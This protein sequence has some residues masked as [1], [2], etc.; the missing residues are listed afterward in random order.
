V[1]GRPSAENSPWLRATFYAVIDCQVSRA[2]YSIFRGS[3]ESPGAGKDVTA[4]GNLNGPLGLAI[5]PNG[6]ILTANGNDGKLV[7]T[8]PGG[9]QV[10]SVYLDRAGSPPGAGNLF[11]LALS[12]DHK[13]IYFDNDGANSLKR[14]S[15]GVIL[16]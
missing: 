5:A 8:T 10:K 2:E 4:N 11:G 6:D 16:S 7:R 3:T 9:V 13:T 1:S 15:A 12:L 14:A